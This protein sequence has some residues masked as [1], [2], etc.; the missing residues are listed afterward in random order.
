M[1]RIDS[2]LV[3]SVDRLVARDVMT[4]H[5]ATVG[6]D[7]VT[8]CWG[9]RHLPVTEYGCSVGL[10]DDGLVSRALEDTA[11]DPST[12]VGEVISRYATQVSTGTDHPRVVP[13]LRASRSAATAVVDEHGHQPGLITLVDLGGRVADEE[14]T[15]ARTRS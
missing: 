11:K 2:E 10:V 4:R 8:R 3:A 15:C 6:Q 7:Q 9:L 13:L 5:L 14:D 1:T 12:P